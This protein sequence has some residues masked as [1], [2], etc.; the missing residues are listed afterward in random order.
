[1]PQVDL[2]IANVAYDTALSRLGD[3]R[4]LRPELPSHVT[5]NLIAFEIVD[6]LRR[7]ETDVEA[8]SA[9]AL[10]VVCLPSSNCR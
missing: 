4:S 7:G 2:Q 3:V 6:R 1:M 8:L 10:N 9:A 5:R